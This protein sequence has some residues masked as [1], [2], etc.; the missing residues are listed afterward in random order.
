M[1]LID[2]DPRWLT[3]DGRRIGLIFMSPASKLGKTSG[4]TWRQ[5]CFFEATPF[6]EQV[7]VVNATMRDNADADGEFDDWQ[8]CREDFAWK[9]IGDTFDT[10]SITPSI[11][12]SAGGLWHG[13]IT[14]G[15]IT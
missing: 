2:L 7:R 4:K 3:S 11:D 14:N 5:T 8:P 10:L 9:M 15:A 6:C 12:G 13:F 1:R